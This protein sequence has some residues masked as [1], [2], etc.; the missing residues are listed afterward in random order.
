M[1][2]PVCAKCKH[3]DSQYGL[4]CTHPKHLDETAYY[5]HVTGTTT[6]LERVD[7]YLYNWEGQCENFDPAPPK[8]SQFQRIK[9]VL[10]G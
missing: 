3:H 2:T 8:V 5:D 7:C 6:R 4:W 9:G 1:N 10:F